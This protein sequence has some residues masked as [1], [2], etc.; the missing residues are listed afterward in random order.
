MIIEKKCFIDSQN[1][2]ITIELTKLLSPYFKHHKY[3]SKEHLWY[4]GDNPDKMFFINSG[5]VKIYD[6][7][8]DGSTITMYIFEQGTLFGFMPFFD[9][10][11]YP[12]YAQVVKES[13]ISTIDRATFNKIIVEKPELSLKLM[14]ILSKRLRDAMLKISENN[15]KDTLSRVASMLVS[16]YLTHNNCYTENNDYTIEMKLPSYEVANYIGVTPETLSRNIKQL[17]DKK[18]I[19]KIGKRIYKILD[20]EQ[21][22]EISSIY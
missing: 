16:I 2:D 9:E 5:I 7:L 14:K 20:L 22:K 17:I 12:A 21:L 18:I 11:P 3:K 10:E 1:N 15:N 8:E 4:D 6:I 19:E 13:D